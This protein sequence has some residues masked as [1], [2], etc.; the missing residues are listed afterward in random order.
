MSKKRVGPLKAIAKKAIQKEIRK[1]EI[2]QGRRLEKYEKRQIQNAVFRKMR[3]RVAVFG[4]IGLLGLGAFIGAGSKGDELKALPEAQGIEI[5]NKQE[6][7]RDIFVNGI[8]VDVEQQQNNQLKE[9]I[10]NELEKLESKEEVLEYV[11]AIY[12]QE[13]NQNNGTQISI[14]DVSFYKQA[15]NVVVYNDKAENGDEIL[16]YCGENEAK[17]LE[18]P[19]DGEKPIISVSV[20]NEGK[21]V[22]E[23][24]AL[25]EKTGEF[26]NVYSQNEEVKEDVNTTLEGIPEVVLTGVNVYISMDEEN[27]YSQV[28]DLYKERFVDALIEYKQQNNKQMEK[29]NL[30]NGTNEIENEL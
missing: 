4:T 24:V 20:K 17:E 2:E 8:K 23:Q 22:R 7:E 15:L 11:K 21:T 12:V 27:T 5:D 14:D 6:S 29:E 25:N 30:V 26:Q 9:E 3:T 10:E 28:K 1:Q 16:R 19:I 18:I 13:Y